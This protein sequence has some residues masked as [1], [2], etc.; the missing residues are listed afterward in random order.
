MLPW[1][2]V[3]LAALLLAMMVIRTPIMFLFELIKGCFSAG[4]P[5]LER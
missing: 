1:F 2:A 5:R 4:V 3:F